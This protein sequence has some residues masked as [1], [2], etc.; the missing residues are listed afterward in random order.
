MSS[1][2]GGILVS[3]CSSRPTHTRTD[4]QPMCLVGSRLL[5]RNSGFNGGAKVPF[6]DDGTCHT[7]RVAVSCV[8]GDYCFACYCFAVS[9]RE[10]RRRSNS[11]LAL[12]SARVCLLRLFVWEDSEGLGLGGG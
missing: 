12:Q 4:R 8:L 1:V 6:Q 11:A 3:S 7:V 5:H 10:I 2:L 9:D